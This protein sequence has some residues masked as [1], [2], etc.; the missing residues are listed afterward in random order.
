MYVPVLSE[1]KDASLKYSLAVTVRSLKETPKTTLSH[2]EV[3]GI[4]KIQLTNH[5]IEK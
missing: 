2:F 3:N 1:E 5:D 4:H